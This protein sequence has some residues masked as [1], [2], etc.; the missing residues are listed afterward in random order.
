MQDERERIYE[1]Y[2]GTVDGSLIVD[3][4][5]QRIQRTKGTIEATFGAHGDMR[6]LLL[7]MQHLGYDLTFTEGSGWFERPYY[8]TADVRTWAELRQNPKEV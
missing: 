6:N 3:Q 1:V 2:S 7:E 4:P 5:H 8:I